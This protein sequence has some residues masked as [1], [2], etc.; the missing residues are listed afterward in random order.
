MK[1]NNISKKKTVKCKNLNEYFIDMMN[2]D[3]F[4]VQVIL[5]FTKRS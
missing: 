1:E 2:N 3:M 5:F 4:D